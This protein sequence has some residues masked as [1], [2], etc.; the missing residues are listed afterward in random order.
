MPVKLLDTSGEAG[1]QSAVH[2]ARL[3]TVRKILDEALVARGYAV[4]DISEEALDARCPNP[5]PACLVAYAG[6]EGGRYA[7]TVSVQKMST[8]IL[9]MA[10][11]IVDV[12]AQKV[13]YARQMTFRGDN[14][15]AWA[16][17]A[18]FLARRLGGFDAEAATPAP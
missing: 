13:V 8:L 3:E 15:L 2:A 16:S 6:E 18:D 10:A 14:D 7:L 4:H 11:N 9:Y 17:A 5:T 12:P 1:D